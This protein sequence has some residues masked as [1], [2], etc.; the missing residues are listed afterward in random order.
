LHRDLDGLRESAAGAGKIGTTGRGIGPAMKTRSVVAP[1]AFAILLISMRSTRSSIVFARTTMPCAPGSAEAGRSRGAARDL[2]EI[3][4]FVLQFAQPVWK[5]LQTVRKAGAR[6]LFEGAQGVLLDVDHGTIRSSRRRTPCR[7]RQL[8]VRAWAVGD[9]LRARI[10][11]AYTTAWVPG[12]SRPN[13]PTKSANVWVSAV[14]S[15][16]LSPGASVAVAGS[17]RC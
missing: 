10:V 9:R 16:G 12:R 13:S 4:P 15:S 1:F 5:R 11:K 8:R 7:G 14:M 3:A 17:T 6:I 2:R